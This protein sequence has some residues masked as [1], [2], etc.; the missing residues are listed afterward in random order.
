MT[1]TVLT[2]EFIERHLSSLVDPPSIW[3]IERGHFY[4]LDLKMCQMK[5]LQYG[6]SWGDERTPKPKVVSVVE[7]PSKILYMD[8]SLND[9]SELDHAGLAPL[10]NLRALNASLNRITRFVGV[11]ICK[12]L[13]YL[14]L[15]HN[16]IQN[17]EG[18]ANCTSLAELNLAMNDIEDLTYVPSL[19][20]LTVLHINN[21]KLK[22]LN[23][24]QAL[25]HL[26]ELHC[27]RNKLRDVIPIAS[28]FHLIML[29]AAENQIE[30][31]QTTADILK[32]LSHLRTL[33]MFNNPIERE[34][35]YNSV[36][37]DTLQLLTL[38]NI[39]VRS[40]RDQTVGY[41]KSGSNNNISGLKESARAAFHEKIKIQK[42]KMEENVRFLQR[43]IIDVQEEYRDYEDRMKKDMESCLS[44]LDGLSLDQARNY[45]TNAIRGNIGSP[46]PPWHPGP[47]YHSDR[48][49]KDKKDYSG[50]KSADEVLRLA[51]NELSKEQAKLSQ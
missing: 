10:R 13:R 12:H 48:T 3:E 47:S 20:N 42:D 49:I 19:P 23:G 33:N 9:L 50:I 34:S 29:N 15:S 32:G 11:E 22:S 2:A 39:S 26:K 4:K 43:R 37:T 31:L 36:L 17:I 18:I 25:S 1:S 41:Y 35:S 46:A 51:V 30:S 6:F 21:N 16:N 8:I 14:N 44:Y 7:T 40:H 28:S 27:Q 38:D 5:S 24:I 45:D